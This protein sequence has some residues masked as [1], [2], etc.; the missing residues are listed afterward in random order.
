MARRGRLVDRST[1]KV[2]YGGVD[3][4]GTDFVRGSKDNGPP[5]TALLSPLLPSRIEVEV[6]ARAYMSKLRRDVRRATSL[7]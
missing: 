3:S 4:G 2:R 5:T 6:D 7:R 1:I